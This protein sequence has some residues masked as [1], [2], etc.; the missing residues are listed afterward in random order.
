MIGRVNV[1]MSSDLISIIIINYNQLLYIDKCLNS[2]LNQTYKN[3]EII[4]VDDGSY[5]GSEIICDNYSKL[6]KRFFVTHKKNEG[7]AIARNTG[8]DIAKGDYI[9]FLDSDDYIPEDF[10]SNLHN[11]IVKND[12]DVAL[13]TVIRVDVDDNLIEKHYME[14]TVL[15]KHECYKNMRLE[16]ASLFCVV[17]NKIYKK[18]VLK[19]LYF[20]NVPHH[21]DK[22]FIIDC[23]D[24][25]KKISVCN[26]TNYYYLNRPDS[27][28]HGS[29]INLCY[30]F[31]AEL[32]KMHIL[33]KNK[34]FD[35]IK[36]CIGFCIS[37]YLQILRNYK[38]Y[39][40][41]DKE[42]LIG[43]FEDSQEIIRCFNNFISLKQ[44]I[45]FIFPRLIV[46]HLI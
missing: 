34:M 30:S 40:T 8:L 24:R 27:L 12:S 43:L 23:Y 20:P 35:L 3:L 26:N 44:K 33:K 45:L 15:D 16:K 7:P 14:E 17:W 32:S 42:L 29:V 5:D 13:C 38:K 4:V 39:N 22:F 25:C 41:K 2:V 28:V 21:D 11:N 9:C 1:T 36:P 18:N 19:Q 6:D 31:N 46:M 37:I 10:I